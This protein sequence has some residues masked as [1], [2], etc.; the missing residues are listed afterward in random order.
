MLRLEET[1]KENQNNLVKDVNIPGIRGGVSNSGANLH[2]MGLDEHLATYTVVQSLYCLPITYWYDL[3]V[4]RTISDWETVPE[5]H[6]KIWIMQR[7]KTMCD[8]GFEFSS[9]SPR[10]ALGVVG[11]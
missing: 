2:R 11:C 3:S 4:Y 1:R 9:T 6:N 7:S 10:L 5:A 8:C